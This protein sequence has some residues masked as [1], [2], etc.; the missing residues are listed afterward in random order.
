MPSDHRLKN[1]FARRIVDGNSALA[2]RLTAGVAHELN[3]PI[4]TVA[5]NF[6]CLREMVAD[7]T[8]LIQAYRGIVGDERVREICAAEIEC[9]LRTESEVQLDDILDDLP[10]LFAESQRGLE[11]IERIARCLRDFSHSDHPERFVP[12]NINRA[13]ENILV[14]A[15]DVYKY[16]ARVHPELGSLPEVACRPQLIHQAL[17]HLIINSVEA[18]ASQQRRDKGNI[19]VRTWHDR[20]AVF[21]QVADDGPGMAPEVRRRAFEPFFTTKP[22]G[23]GLGLSTCHDIMVRI[24]QG[25]LWFECPPPAGTVFTGRIP[26]NLS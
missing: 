8:R 9:L 13:V 22:A 23:L 4:N 25:S 1:D 18:I 12:F 5:A 6:A 2:G 21:F 24:H 16:G 7:L 14:V 19:H 20:D 17:L 3:N 26:A 15:A 10:G 11:R